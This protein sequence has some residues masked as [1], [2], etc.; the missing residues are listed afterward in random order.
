VSR[1]GRK[2]L[3]P[4]I[5]VRDRG[6]AA[7]LLEA[8]NQ[9]A[10]AKESVEIKGWRVLWEA[11]DLRILLDTRKYLYDKRD[12]KATQP[13][14]HGGGGPIRVQIETNVKMADPHDQ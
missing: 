3:P 10:A 5:E 14:D 7:R 11:Q 9:K 13:I 12:G 1:A 8:L 6:A 4:I 2:P